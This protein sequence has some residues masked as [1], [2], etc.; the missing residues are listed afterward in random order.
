[1][2]LISARKPLGADHGGE[3]GSQH[4]ERNLAVVPQ[5]LGQIDGGHAA[6]AQFPLDPVAVG[7]G[8]GAVDR[9]NLED[10]AAAAAPRPPRR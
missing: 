4:L 2:V 9:R 3:L 7:E 5:I 8:R 10:L 1:V 6:L